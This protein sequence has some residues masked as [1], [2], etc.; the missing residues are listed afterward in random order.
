[1]KVSFGSNTVLFHKTSQV[2]SGRSAALL[3]ELKK[4]VKDGL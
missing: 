3:A 1:M 4:R 2:G